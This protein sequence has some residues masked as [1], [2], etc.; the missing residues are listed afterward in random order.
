MDPKAPE[1]VIVEKPH[2]PF[3]NASFREMRG[4]WSLRCG[5]VGVLILTVIPELSDQFPNIAPS[6]IAWF[7]KHGA[8]WVPVLGAVIAIVAR[9]VSQAYIADQVRKLFKVN[10]NEPK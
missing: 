7:P 2:H 1:V 4:W 5:V 10:Q 6:L 3:F 8:Q 9:V